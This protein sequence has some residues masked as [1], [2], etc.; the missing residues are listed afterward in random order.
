[1]TLYHGALDDAGLY[2]RAELEALAERHANFAYRPCLMDRGEDL[3]AVVKAD[4]AL[5][6][7]GVYLCGD[8]PLVERLRKALFLAGARLADI[9]ADA[10]AAA[11]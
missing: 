1:M 9:R 5:K 8:A 11:A 6:G 7:A 2:L 4:P 3:L 10:F